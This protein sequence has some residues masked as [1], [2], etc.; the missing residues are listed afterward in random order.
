MKNY[1]STSSLSLLFLAMNI[2]SIKNDD[3]AVKFEIGTKLYEAG[4]YK[5]AIRLLSKLHP[6]IE[7]NHKLKSCFTCFHRLIT[8]RNNII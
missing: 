2:K 4:K 5:K 3:V 6:L 1:I 8:R 7:E